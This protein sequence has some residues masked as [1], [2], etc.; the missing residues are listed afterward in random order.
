MPDGRIHPKQ[1]QALNSASQA[2]GA[3]FLNSSSMADPVPA[4]S[5][6]SGQATTQAQAGMGEKGLGSMVSGMMGKVGGQGGYNQNQQYGYNNVSLS[7]ELQS[8]ADSLG[9][10]GINKDTVR[11]TRRPRSRAVA[12]TWVR[13]VPAWPWVAQP[14]RPVCCSPALSV[15]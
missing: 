8:D 5:Q 13:S 15:R 12:S 3:G 9:A 4:Y 14:P 7:D 2:Q 11:A 6:T 1:A 10:R